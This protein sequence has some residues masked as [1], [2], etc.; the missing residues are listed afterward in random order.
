LALDNLRREPLAYLYSVGYRGLRVFIIEG[1]DDRQTTQQF[2]GSGSVYKVATVVSSGLL[3]LLGVGVWTAWRRGCAIALPAILIAY[4]PVTLAF[5]LTN[6]RYSITVQ[7][8]VFI[9]VSAAIVRALELVGVWPPIASS[10]D[11]ESPRRVDIGTAH[12]L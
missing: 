8:F 9:F 4:V 12:R 5:L 10:S 6:M 7:P 1:D 2:S 11:V 3:V